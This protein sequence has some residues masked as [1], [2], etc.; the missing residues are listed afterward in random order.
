M[1]FTR[2][3]LIGFFAVIALS[4]NEESPTSLVKVQFNL[5]VQADQY[6]DGGRLQS[7]LEIPNGAKLLISVETETG[8]PV[9]TF[10]EVE[11]LRVGGNIVTAPLHFYPGTFQIV[12]FLLVDEANNV[13]FATPKRGSPLANYIRNPLVVKLTITGGKA[14][15]VQ[16]DVMD[17]AQATPES[18]GYVSFNINVVHPL[19]VVVFAATANGAVM[20][21][22]KM[23]IEKG[24]PILETMLLNAGINRVAFKHSADENYIMRIS[25][26]GYQTYVRN[27]TYD[28]IISELNGQPLAITLTP[29]MT[30]TTPYSASF[31]S[32]TLYFGGPGAEYTIDWGDGTPSQTNGDLIH[33]YENG[34]RYSINIAGE[35]EKITVLQGVYGDARF[36]DADFTLLTGLRTFD[37]ALG[38]LPETLDL[39]TCKR[40]ETLYATQCNGVERI[41]VPASPDLYYISIAGSRLNTAAVSSVIDQLHANAELFEIHNG[42]FRLHLTTFPE[43]GEEDL[44]AGPPNASALQKLR[45]L[46]DKYHW[47]VQPAF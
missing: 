24:E 43:P 44:M 9:M 7:P 18:F 3:V 11:L 32:I 42:E 38:G 21:S 14:K 2:L 45:E 30:I 47:D 34:G 35:L 41:I 4:C 39:S 12:D 46:R 28:Q 29:G 6:N 8:A 26:P 19:S 15:V 16:M 40:L 25:K 20:T 10:E 22:A 1:N 13:L 5:A 36:F 17:V 33:E 37:I 27:F 31:Q 23:T